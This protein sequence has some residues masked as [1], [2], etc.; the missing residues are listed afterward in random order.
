MFGPIELE[1]S[2]QLAASADA[3]WEAASSMEGVNQELLPL[4]R[5][6]HPADRC[7]VVSW[8]VHRD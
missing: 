7:G 3:V 4:V 1:L 5:M 6:T 8:S 2:S